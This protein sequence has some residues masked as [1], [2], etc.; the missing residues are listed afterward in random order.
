MLSTIG[1]SSPVWSF[2]LG[3][4]DEVLAL[5]A[6]DL[7]LAVVIGGTTRAAAIGKLRLDR[8]AGI[9][10]S[11]TMASPEAWVAGHQAAWPISAGVSIFSAVSVGAALVLSVADYDAAARAAAL[12]PIAAV[13]LAVIP[14]IVLAHRAATDINTDPQELSHSRS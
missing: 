12:A 8:L 4:T 1:F 10:T 13:I 11:A 5:I 7:L 14:V 6:V 2:A 9:R 3:I